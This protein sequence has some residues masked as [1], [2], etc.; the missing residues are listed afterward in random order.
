MYSQ[1]KIIMFNCDHGCMDAVDSC[2]KSILDFH[3]AIL[4]HLQPCSFLRDLYRKFVFDLIS[5]ARQHFRKSPLR[6]H[7]TVHVLIS[8]VDGCRVKL[9]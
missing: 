4:V 7:K 2:M 5:I 6:H 1:L 8:D 9:G 3:H